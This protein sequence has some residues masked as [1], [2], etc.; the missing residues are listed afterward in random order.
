MSADDQGTAILIEHGADVN[1]K[2]KG[3]YTPL[4]SAL[5]RYSPTA[6][7]L[8]LEHGGDVNACID[9]HS[10]VYWVTSYLQECPE[11]AAII[12]LLKQHGGRLTKKEGAG[13]R[14]KSRKLS[15]ERPPGS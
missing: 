2:D 5:G 8:L 12:Q 9:G 4:H 10:P 3:G 14:E 1:A 15:L 11:K 6:V 13:S 7:K